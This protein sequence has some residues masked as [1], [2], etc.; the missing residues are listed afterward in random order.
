MPGQ[1]WSVS[2]KRAYEQ[3]VQAFDAGIRALAHEHSESVRFRVLSENLLRVH[4]LVNGLFTEGVPEQF[5]H[6]CA[7]EVE[8]LEVRLEEAAESFD[9]E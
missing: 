7:I 4:P 3:V 9:L 1:V 5:V 2:A 6:N 8:R